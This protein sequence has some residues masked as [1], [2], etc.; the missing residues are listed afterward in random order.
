MRNAA[1]S[2]CVALP[3]A[4]VVGLMAIVG[5]YHHHGPIVHVAAPDSPSLVGV[6][7]EG[8]AACAV[9]SGDSVAH[10]STPPVAPAAG[11]AAPGVRLEDAVAE[12]LVA[13]ASASPRSPPA[14]APITA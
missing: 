12:E 2:R 6:S 4:F 10:E 9:C 1:L 11:R 7:D 14:S 3:A 13:L 8:P 5:C